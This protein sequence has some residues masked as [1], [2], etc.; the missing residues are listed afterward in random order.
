MSRLFLGDKDKYAALYEKFESTSKTKYVYTGSV[1]LIQKP[2]ERGMT[3]PVKDMPLMKYKNELYHIGKT[4]Y[5]YP[6]GKGELVLPYEGKPAVYSGRF[7]HGIPVGVGF[8]DG[9]K[10]CVDVQFSG[11]YDVS[12]ELLPD[13]HRL[14]MTED[15][16][17]EYMRS[18]LKR[19]RE[20][21]GSEKGSKKQKV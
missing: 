21:D 13:P 10:F 17:Q 2:R 12:W 8:L 1:L 18:F 6:E 16:Q 5:M 15:E 14:D 20:E 19:A 4:F 11:N 3:L 9:K 7:D